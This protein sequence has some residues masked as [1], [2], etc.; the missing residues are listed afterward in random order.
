VQGWLA[1]AYY[2]S[3][4]AQNESRFRQ[5]DRPESTYKLHLGEHDEWIFRVEDKDGKGR[6]QDHIHPRYLS[7]PE[8]QRLWLALDYVQLIEAQMEQSGKSKT[9]M[10]EFLGVFSLDDLSNKIGLV[11]FIFIPELGF[12]KN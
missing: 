8:Q 5:N 12:N 7:E 9:A 3:Q 11:E 10:C 2:L 1:G 4:L 6:E